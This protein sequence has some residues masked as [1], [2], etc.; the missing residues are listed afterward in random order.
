MTLTPSSHGKPSRVTGILVRRWLGQSQSCLTTGLI[1]TC[2]L[3]LLAGCAQEGPIYLTLPDTT[4]EDAVLD[5][6]TGCKPGDVRCPSL[7]ESE[8]CTADAKTWFSQSCQVGETCIAEFGGCVPH[9]CDPFETSCTS[10]KTYRRCEANGMDYEDLLCEDAYYCVEGQ[11]LYGPCLGHVLLVLDTSGSMN[12]HWESV[13]TS[14][15]ALVESNPNTRFGLMVFPGDSKCSVSKKP[16]ISMRAHRAKEAFE[17]YFDENQPGSSTPL[18]EALKTLRAQQGTIFQDQEGTV[19]VLSDGEDTCEKE[20][21]KAELPDALAIETQAL[22]DTGVKTYV[23]G[24]N[25]QGNASQLDAIAS[26]G[27]TGAETHIPAGNES[28]LDHAFT[29]II[30]DIK[31]CL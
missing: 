29:G 31:L 12:P 19:V 9:I 21:E 15:L 16:I 7:L 22:S 13:Q 8:E 10:D 18:L 23:I 20:L 27:N 26:H 25:Y 1:V 24:Y 3:G 30:N 28:E 17:A 11:C 4:G 14:I 2:L 6:S 5:T